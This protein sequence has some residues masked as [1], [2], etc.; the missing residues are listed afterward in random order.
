MNVFLFYGNQITSHFPEIISSWKPML[1]NTHW[2]DCCFIL[3]SEK[4]IDYNSIPEDLKPMIAER[5][6]SLTRFTEQAG[7]MVGGFVRG[8]LN[9]PGPILL[10]CVCS[11]IENENLNGF[12][13]N[14]FIRS[15]CAYFIGHPHP[16]IY[17][18]LSSHIPSLQ[19]QTRFVTELYSED[20]FEKSTTYFLSDTNEYM[21][22]VTQQQQLRMLICE[23]ALIIKNARVLSKRSIFSL[24]YSVLNANNS[25]LS[26]LETKTLIENWLRDAVNNESTSPDKH[27]WDIATNKV[28]FPNEINFK[29]AITEWIC[30]LI[31][32]LIRFPSE[33]ARKNNRILGSL[34]SPSSTPEHRKKHILRFFE[35]NNSTEHFDSVAKQYFDNLLTKLL[36]D[37]CSAQ[38]KNKQPSTIALLEAIC[39]VLKEKAEFNIPPFTV[40]PIPQKKILESNQA[41]VDRCCELCER[42][43]YKYCTDKA[44]HVMAG[45]MLQHIS[46]IIHF[47][48]NVETPQS[49]FPALSIPYADYSVLC[50]KYPNILKTI[51]AVLASPKHYHALLTENRTPLFD[52]NG[53]PLLDEWKQILNSAVLQLHVDL[54]VTNPTFLCRLNKEC[55]TAPALENFIDTY[56]SQPF[57]VLSYAGAP[58]NAE[59][60]Y[61]VD[62][63]L[64]D[65]PWTAAHR[66]DAYIVNTDNI[67]R[68]DRF[69]IAE[70][71]SSLLQI[72]NPALFPYFS[73]TDISSEVYA[74]NDN[75]FQDIVFQRP[76]EENKTTFD[77]Q[78]NPENKGHFNMNMRISRQAAGYILTWDWPPHTHNMFVHVE[79]EE[80][81]IIHSAYPVNGG[82]ALN[83]LTVSQGEL[84]YG[85][86]S[87][88]IT[89]KNAKGTTYWD[90][91]DFCGKR[92][93]LSYQF[94]NQGNKITLSLHGR[95][96][97]LHQL[98]L[99]NE[100]NDQVVFYPLAPSENKTY[101]GLQLNGSSTLIINPTIGYPSLEIK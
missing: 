57:M 38:F 63:D 12:E 42:D 2:N 78:G 88:T 18:T 71:V 66:N 6:R 16:V 9:G 59:T 33:V 11:N 99:R 17:L 86:L 20:L 82:N 62:N 90:K 89:G 61:L 35:M 98:L 15:F 70:S 68:I 43:A 64:Q 22:R 19:K 91:K 65:H 75:V 87:I 5:S 84:P 14:A 21:G 69:N 67:E 24:G 92:D 52:P 53:N 4:G 44:V 29:E 26:D 96:A 77:S 31:F 81:G 72:R 1:Q 7:T 36:C 25:E 101:S 13:L 55:P 56:I 30:Q 27:F 85:K 48:S 39:S 10:H 60:K 58:G 50:N 54:N 79:S 97:F 47:I 73:D 3:L 41:Y 34:Y 51:N 45:Y 76:V 49:L 46:G 32:G 94:S 28:P 93:L 40:S 37:P 8:L 74:D 23:L 83:L 95:D 100:E 80:R